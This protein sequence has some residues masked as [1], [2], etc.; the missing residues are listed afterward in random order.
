MGC[1]SWFLQVA[2]DVQQFAQLGHTLDQI[3]LHR[4]IKLLLKSSLYWEWVCGW[5]ADLWCCKNCLRGLLADNAAHLAD[6]LHT[7]DQILLHRHNQ[8][9]PMMW[10]GKSEIKPVQIL[11]ILIVEIQYLFM[12]HICFHVFLPPTA[13]CCCLSISFALDGA[14]FDRNQKRSERIKV[15]PYSSIALT[16][17]C[18]TEF[19]FIAI[20]P[21]NDCADWPHLKVLP[22]NLAADAFARCV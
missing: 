6:G 8:L 9:P 7:A 12:F 5:S 4:H 11:T 14:G 3:L 20:P 2:D 19:F 18:F 1:F 17:S 22:F 21:L 10:S 15:L 13:M 16:R